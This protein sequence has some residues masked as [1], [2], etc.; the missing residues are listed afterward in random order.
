[1]GIK[2]YIRFL[3]VLLFILSLISYAI[4]QSKTEDQ[5]FDNGIIKKAKFYFNIGDFYSALQHYKKLCNADPKNMD[6]NY[7]LAM[8]YLNTNIDKK[9]AIP[10]LE[11]VIKQQNPPKE[12]F[13]ELGKAYHY[14]HL[15]NKAIIQYEI[16]KEI[17]KDKP[18][19]KRDIKR[20]IEM[21][22]NATL[23]VNDPINIDFVN[24][25]K[26][27]NSIYPDYNPFTSADES[28]LIFSSRR[29]ENIGSIMDYGL[30]TADIYI[31]A[32][33]SGNWSK[34]KNIRQINTE[35]DEETIGL[36]A[37]GQKLLEYLDNIEAYG[38]IG[39]SLLRGSSWQ[40][41][42]IL[43][44]SVNSPA[45]ETGATISNDGN[46]IY[47]SSDKKEG[48]FGG[49]DLYMAQ[50]LPTGEWGRPFNLGSTINTPYDEDAPYLFLDG[51]TLYFSSKG[52]NS[53]G[54]YDLFKSTWNAVNRTWSE[55]ENLGYPINN[56][57]DNLYFSIS[58]NGQH[59]YIS[60]LRDEGLGDLDIYKV[61]FKDTIVPMK[62]TLIKGALFSDNSIDISKVEITLSDKNNH[63]VVGKYIANSQTG[64]FVIIIPPGNYELSIEGEKLADYN[65]I[66]NI[67]EYNQ[68]IE[69]SKE[70]SLIKK[71]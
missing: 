12:A 43:S 28:I 49:K 53:M 36:S 19:P 46:T 24:L 61:T 20:Q 27:V 56:A 57:D 3:F 25:G 34:A 45:L 4:C 69:I 2:T 62:L 22:N 17:T 38:D 50:K 13:Y 65:E 55:P 11:F 18:D 44:L 31:S 6:Y 29:K 21:C 48:S 51:Q 54:G 26:D 63:S 1:M 66:I 5:A 59:A 10:H 8:C 68:P 39:M 14:A 60:A 67:P 16:Y 41:P 33:K 32:N 23:L 52:H 71:P 35:L 9:K 42:K 40:K 70:I 64:K 37:D 58:F 47:F 15:F 7:K 30:Y